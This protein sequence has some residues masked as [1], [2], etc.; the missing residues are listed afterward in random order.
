MNIGTVIGNVLLVCPQC[1]SSHGYVQRESLL[2]P[3]EAINS[4]LYEAVKLRKS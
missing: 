1:H 4:P 2:R 3:A